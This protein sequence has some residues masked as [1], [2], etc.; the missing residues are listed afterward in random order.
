MVNCEL[1]KQIRKFIESRVQW[2]EK[3]TQFGLFSRNVR[4]AKGEEWKTIENNKYRR[5]RKGKGK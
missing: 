4:N 3:H 1:N 2:S 5:N